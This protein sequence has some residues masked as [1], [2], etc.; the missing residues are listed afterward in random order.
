MVILY[1][2]SIVIANLTAAHFGLSAVYI[3]A[4]L[5]IGLDLTARDWL[6][7]KWT[8]NRWGKMLALIVS[9]GVLSW[10]M[11]KDAGVIAIASTAAFCAA[12][13]VDTI[14]YQALHDKKRIW[15]VNASN[16]LSAIVDSSVFITIAFGFNAGN[17]ATQV[18]CKAL[19]GAF[20]FWVLMYRPPAA[21]LP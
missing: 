16:V 21:R 2:A 19:G 17:I 14:V 5:L 20:W 3:N 10:I 9:G 13:L 18:L 8:K 11:N 1:L 7:D 12:A 4:F 6:H 15:K